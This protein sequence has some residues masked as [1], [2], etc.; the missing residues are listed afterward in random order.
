MSANGQPRL[1]TGPLLA[2]L[3]SIGV[4]VAGAGF[5][6]FLSA[7]RQPCPRASECTQL[8]IG[9]VERLQGDT[10][11]LLTGVGQALRLDTVVVRPGLIVAIHDCGH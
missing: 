2:L 11:I 5:L 9:T 6:F 10:L 8:A 1:I 7:D 4:L 3:T